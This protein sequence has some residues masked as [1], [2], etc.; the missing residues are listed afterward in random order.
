MNSSSLMFVRQILVN[1]SL[2]VRH[3]S[4][5]YG[6]SAGKNL[7]FIKTAKKVHVCNFRA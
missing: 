3:V 5:I 2:Y 4:C 1:F 7:V 6:N